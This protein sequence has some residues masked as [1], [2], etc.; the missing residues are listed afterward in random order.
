MMFRF[1]DVGRRLEKFT[2]HLLKF[3]IKIKILNL[4]FKS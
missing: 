1:H 2:I 4:L 3:K